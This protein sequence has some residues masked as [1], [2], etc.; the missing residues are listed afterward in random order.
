M[1]CFQNASHRNAGD[2]EGIFAVVNASPWRLRL[3]SFARPW[4]Q[5]PLFVPVAGAILC[6]A[7][8]AYE[9]LALLL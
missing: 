1:H 2:P 3:N 6:A 9:G 5:V 7:M 4:F 8:L